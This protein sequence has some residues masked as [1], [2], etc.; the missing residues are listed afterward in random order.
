MSA[1]GSPD[2]TRTVEFLTNSREIPWRRRTA[3]ERSGSASPEVHPAGTC[4]LA[5]R[6]GKAPAVL[7]K[8]RLSESVV[9]LRLT[10]FLR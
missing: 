6:F 1:V 9:S 5:P 3:W 8:A 4:A 7:R 2:S 10:T